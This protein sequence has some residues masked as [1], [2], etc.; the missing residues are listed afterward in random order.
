MGE[1][2]GFAVEPAA[3]NLV[4]ARLDW[5]K[6]THVATGVSVTVFGADGKYCRNG[7]VNFEI[8]GGLTPFFSTKIYYF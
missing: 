3:P 1:K 8:I 6:V 4:H 2:L 5:C 7:Y